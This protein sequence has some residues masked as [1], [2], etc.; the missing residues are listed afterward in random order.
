MFEFGLHST[1]SIPDNSRSLQA[2]K[3]YGL[4]ERKIPSLGLSSAFVQ[5][6]S[7]QHHHAC[8][9]ASHYF[10]S[11]G[12][13]ESRP[14][15]QRRFRK[16]DLKDAHIISQ[17][18]RKFIACLI[19]D[20]G[21]DDDDDSTR[22]RTSGGGR[23][24]VLID[25]HAADERVRVERFLKELCLGFLQRQ[26]HRQNVLGESVGV[27]TKVLSPPVPV[28]LTR[29]EVMRLAGSNTFQQAFECWGITF[30]NL[31]SVGSGEGIANDGTYSQVFVHSV[32]TVVSEK[33][34]A[35]GS[36]N[37]NLLTGL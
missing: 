35:D 36:R 12:K 31:A 5:Q 27:K 4:T 14:A 19:R 7:T 1:C 18:D 37:C 6:D 25:Q 29:H 11:Q 32:P 15:L 2:N 3:V 28:L 21:G 34:R 8:G 16:E 26:Q 13:L 23:A 24:L 10:Q 9:P 20:D 22:E 30:E 33:V 17:V